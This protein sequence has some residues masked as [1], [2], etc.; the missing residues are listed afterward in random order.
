M[1]KARPGGRA[2]HA[3]LIKRLLLY[4]PTGG[5]VRSRLA[6]PF[7]MHFGGGVF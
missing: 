6:L 2:C 3:A 7:V 1:R 4:A 5:N